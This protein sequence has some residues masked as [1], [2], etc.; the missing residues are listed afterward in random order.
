M[1]EKEEEN[2]EAVEDEPEEE[3]EPEFKVPRELARIELGDPVDPK[4]VESLM[5]RPIGAN[6]RRHLPYKWEVDLLDPEVAGKADV[7]YLKLMGRKPKGTKAYYWNGYPGK[8]HLIE[9]EVDGKPSIMLRGERVDLPPVLQARYSQ[10]IEEKKLTRDFLDYVPKTRGRR[11]PA[12]KVEEK[13][14]PRVT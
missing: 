7:R 14:E 9:V 6:P 4:L 11:Q 5:N 1:A 13:E 10:Y 3:P 8:L 2:T 12:P